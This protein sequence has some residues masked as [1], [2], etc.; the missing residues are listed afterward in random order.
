MR[1]KSVKDLDG[2]RE[3]ILAK[4][5]TGGTQV[6]ISTHSSCCFL[7]GS[8]A[9]AD[10]LAASLEK[11]GL[12]GK[13]SVTHT[14]CL[15]FCEIEPI[16]IVQPQDV[17]YQN[18]KAED[19]E[20]IVTETLRDGKVVE[21]LL[22]V[23]PVSGEKKKSKADN[24]FYRKQLR[25][26]SG[27]NERI[28]PQSIDD[29]IAIG[30]YS[31]MAKALTSMSPEEVI[32]EIKKSGLRGRGGGGFPAGRKWETCRKAESSDGARYIICNADEGDPGAYMDRSV[33]EGNPHS[34]LEGMVIASHAIGSRQGYIYVRAEY[35]LAV[36]H[37][38]KALSQ[39]EEYGL[40]GEN[41]LGT[42]HDFSVQVSRGAGAF[43]CGESTALMASLEGRVGRPRAKYV[44]TVERGLYQKPSCLNNV[45]T[46][47]NVPIV[48]NKGAEEYCK[49]G[50]EGSPGTKIFSLVG[51]INNTGLV[52]VPMGITLREIIFDI[53][54]GIPGGKKFKAVQ[55]GGPSGGCIP[56]SLLDLPVDFDELTK[57]GSMMG[58][59]GMI[60]MDEDTCMVDVARYFLDFLKGESCGKCVACREGVT[61]MLEILER[62]CAGEGQDG[63]IATLEEIGDYLVDTALCAL[64]STAANPVLTT[65]KYFSDEYEAHIREEHCPAG[66]C[67]NLFGY[68]IEKEA[69]K[70]CGVCRKKCPVEAIAGEK[71]VAHE[72]DREKCIKC[73]VCLDSCKFDAV[74]KV[75]VAEV[76]A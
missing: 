48:I 3:S 46:W 20:R 68:T 53:G 58:S 57:A 21:D 66:V 6:V 76:V 42:G 17:L 69:C 70:A 19:V 10:A 62:I 72:I 55:T 30:G 37:V 44:H 52:E 51:K 9:V 27:P 23:D 67:K 36:E 4:K 18:V 39:A 64:G 1:L 5:P 60:V 7:K 33:L 75:R 34:V 47:A 61:R 73:G 15:G 29:Y 32:E 12:A 56:E 63:D 40:L 54:G 25:Q 16:V 13:V 43:V 22:Y 41:I 2:L 49:V 71:K 28:E 65:L 8:R 38:Q 24:P 26:V 50:T 35:P 14:G 45:E 31:A 59:G 11:N 74:K